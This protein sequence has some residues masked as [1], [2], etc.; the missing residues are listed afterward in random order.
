VVPEFSDDRL[1]VSSLVLA[2][3]MQKV[4][5]KNVGAGSFVIGDTR[6]RPRVPEAGKPAASSAI[7]G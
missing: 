5:T 6:V 1:A 2:D 3:D 7:N 4:P